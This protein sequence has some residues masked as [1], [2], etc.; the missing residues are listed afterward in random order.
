[1]SH[2]TSGSRW[3]FVGDS[4]TELIGKLMAKILLTELL[5]ANMA[6]VLQML[7]P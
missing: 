7:L 5:T 1:M 3:K 6:N 4:S 2:S